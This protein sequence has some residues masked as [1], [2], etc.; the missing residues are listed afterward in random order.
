MAL[1]AHK[2]VPGLDGVRGIAIL[3]VVVHH[4]AFPI[5]VVTA[6]DRAFVNWTLAGW[7]GVDLFFVLSGFLITGIL[8]DAKGSPN[9]FR[10]FYARRVLRIFPLYYAAVA[11]LVISGMIA[12]E[13]EWYW[14]HAVNIFASVQGRIP[15]VHGHFWSL[16][17]E[18]QFYLVWPLCIWA[19]SRRGFRGLVLGII[20]GAM[21]ARCAFWAA[22]LLGWLR[23]N[24]VWFYTLTPFRADALAMGALIALVARENG[25]VPRLQRLAP[26]A[27]AVSIT[28]IAALAL[29]H[30]HY[31]ASIWDVQA[32][33]YTATALGGAALVIC[34]LTGRPHAL[35]ALLCHRIPRSFGKYS[36]CLYVVHP[37]VSHAL[38]LRNL[39]PRAT[40]G[41]GVP[42]G[43]IF[44]VVV[45]ALSYAVSWVSWRVFEAP[46]LSL[47]RYFETQPSRTAPPS[48]PVPAE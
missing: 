48:L 27:G 32:V 47:K 9:Y 20:V 19:M 26:W 11:L 39:G 33:G 18:E 28:V 25:G 45:T 15:F 12:R 4:S 29:R 10:N 5:P 37:F 35:S 2:H 13:Q 41:G 14:A 1:S 6:T 24:P 3:L 38:E 44:I 40:A 36:Y 30:G 34:A 21:L 42:T 46:I 7:V 17:V 16:G 23:V 43:V 8:L 22:H 31:Q